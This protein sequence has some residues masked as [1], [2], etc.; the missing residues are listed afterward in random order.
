[1]SE[2]AIRVADVTKIYKL[3]D[4]PK[5]RLKESLGL[6]RKKC[7]QEHYALNHIN[8]EV[9]KGETVGIIGTNGS[10]K[11]TMLKLI[12]GVLTPSSGEIQVDGRISALLELGAGFNMEYTGIE[13]IYLNGTMIGFSRNEIDE[14]MQEILD[15]ADIGEF[16]HQPVKSYSS[17]MFVRLAFAVAININ[18]EILIVDE[19]LS[20]GDVF[21]Q[22]KCYRKFEEFKQQGKTILFVSHDL[23]S[24]TK[25][26]DRAILLN[27]GEK[28]FEGTPKETVDIYKKVLVNQFEPSELETDEDANDIT[29]FSKD[30]DW[31]KSIQV[32]PELIEYGEK[33]AEIIDYA[34]LDENGLITNTFMKG[35]VFSVRMKIQAH[36]EVKEPIFAFTIKNLQGIELT[37]TNTTYEKAEVPPME[38][39]DIREVTFTQ[40][41][42]LQGGEYLVSLGCTGYQ[43]GD[44]Q[45]FHR[46]YDVCSLTVISDK[47]TVGYYDMNSEVS[48][49]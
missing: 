47:N 2:T 42:D 46:L 6:T 7:Y 29:K 18:P 35:T 13:N 49:R 39:G 26:C 24:I 5:D 11:S 16:V 44:F 14:K 19:A 20:V 48:L 10:G 41:L 25:Y 33:S 38:P 1:M 45:V 28:I 31:K 34:L 8:F 27:K 23:G 9:K 30:K 15:F 3:Y 40:R 36:K 4:N 22:A 12:T 32:N 37:G 17:G 43:D 21:F